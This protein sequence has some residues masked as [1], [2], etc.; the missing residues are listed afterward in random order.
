M[1]KV[2]PGSYSLFEDL[3]KDK[4]LYCSYKANIVIAFLDN[5]EWYKKK[6]KKRCLNKEDIHKIANLSADYF[7]SLLIGKKS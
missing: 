4:G 5:I 3:K 6:Y 1:K 2:K 7:L